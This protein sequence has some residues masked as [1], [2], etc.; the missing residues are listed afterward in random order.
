MLKSTRIS[1]HGKKMHSIYV[2]PVILYDLY[3]VTWTRKFSMEIENITKPY[4]VHNHQSKADR[5]ITVFSKVIN[6]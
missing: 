1:I 3:C 2:L 6:L 4:D 5:Q